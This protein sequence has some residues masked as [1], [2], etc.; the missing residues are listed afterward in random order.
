MA[1]RAAGDADAIVAAAAA[2]LL[3]VAVFAQRGRVKDLRQDL[4]ELMRK[5]MEA[6][7]QRSSIASTDRAS[8]AAMAIYVYV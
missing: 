2:L 4:R 8:L 3:V 7:A 6:I 1:P 5:D